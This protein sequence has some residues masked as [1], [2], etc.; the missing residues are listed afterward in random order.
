MSGSIRTVALSGLGGVLVAGLVVTAF[1]ED[2]LLVDLAEV[3]A[4]TLVITVD[5]EGETRVRDTYDVNAPITGTLKRLPLE[6]GDRVHRGKTIVAQVEPA[7]APLLDAR[8]RAEA[9]ASLQ[10]AEA[11]LRFAQAEI[12]R[13]EAEQ[14]F[15]QTHFDRTKA[16]T[17]T[18][19]SSITRLEDA[20]L[21][22]AIAEAAHISAQASLEMARASHERAAAV[23]IDPEIGASDG[24]CC[25]TLYAPADGVVLEQ[26]NA[27][28]RPVVSGEML[29]SI[30]DPTNLEVVVD[31][32]SAD[33][34]RLREGAGARLERWG[35]DAP[36]DAVVRR[37]EPTARTVVSALG[38]EEQ[39]VD[40]I[41]DITS[42]EMEWAGLGQ[43]FSVFVRIEE[44]R[45]DDAVLVPL[46]ALFQQDDR[47]FTY[48]DVDGVAVRREIEIGPRD[49]R[50]ATVQTGLQLNDR[51]VTHPPDSIAA[52]R[53][54][55]E[56]EAF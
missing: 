12:T 18:G 48:L 26:P 24:M 55:A 16:L 39:R 21:R 45:V 5:A 19:A 30:G 35:S 32:L 15:A 36:L 28:A 2:A 22:L 43:G 38:I 53:R 34:T 52:G 47:W 40:V 4:G 23:L 42:P 17:E 31:L 11:S 29:L 37:L 20:S 3:S 56:R 50:W 7:A 13:T 49:G 44:E 6:V 54:L 9:V 14:R 25:V 41:L 8:S 33:A 1:R 10:E 46:S 27:S 51:V